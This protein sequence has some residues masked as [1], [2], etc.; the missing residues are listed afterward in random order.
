MLVERPVGGAV[1]GSY[2][3]D[4]WRFD[5]LA[6]LHR[7]EGPLEGRLHGDSTGRAAHR[8][9][10]WPITGAGAYQCCA[11]DGIRRQ[12]KLGERIPEAQAQDC[13]RG[14]SGGR[15]LDNEF[16]G[17]MA[18]RLTEWIQS[19]QIK[20]TGI[21][22]IGGNDLPPF[23]R[24][25]RINWG[26]HHVGPG[27]RD[28]ASAL[29]CQNGHNRRGQ[30]DF[31]LVVQRI[32][33]DHRWRHIL[34]QWFEVGRYRVGYIAIR[35][36]RAGIHSQDDVFA[37]DCLAGD[38]LAL[39]QGLHA[40]GGGYRLSRLD[41]AEAANLTRIGYRNV[42]FVHQLGVSANEQLKA[43]VESRNL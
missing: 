17:D 26:G 43:G 22:Q 21:H 41:V 10:R 18:H 33:A 42:V 14:T 16:D 2:Q 9:A 11:V 39:C 34:R 24:I 25:V 4:D 31:S 32:N 40:E 3:G 6:G 7:A 27:V 19:F 8:L 28:E 1:G 13:D 23:A 30:R 15:I 38:D 35:T 37:G 12:E 20:G 36:V 5:S 29:W